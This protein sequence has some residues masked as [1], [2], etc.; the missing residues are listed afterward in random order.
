MSTVS[1]DGMLLLYAFREFWLSQNPPEV[2]LQSENVVQQPKGSPTS[3]MQKRL[4]QRG[5]ME[6]F[7][8][9]SVDYIQ[10]TRELLQC[11]L[12]LT[13]HLLA[14]PNLETSLSPCTSTTSPTPCCSRGHVACPWEWWLLMV[15]CAPVRCIDARLGE[16]TRVAID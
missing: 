2:L 16:R 10:P 4:T 1:P 14:D 8:N 7:Q 12:F 11:V 9:F 6:S 13:T 3:M 5:G 15:C